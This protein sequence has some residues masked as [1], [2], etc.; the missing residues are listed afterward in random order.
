MA[1]SLPHLL[2][3]YFRAHARERAVGQRRGYRME[4][5]TYG[6]V[7]ELAAGFAKE[8]RSLGIAKGDRV[9]LW[10]E[11]SAQ[12]VAAYLGCAFAGAVVVP[13]DGASSPGK[14][15]RS[16]LPV[17]RR[18]R[19]IFRRERLRSRLKLCSKNRAHLGS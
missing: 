4:W 9:M 6:Q 7:F 16:S 18:M 11:N 13:M 8:L 12:W 3:P 15:R 2:L 10:G 14:F 19:N 17:Q 1:E 5:F